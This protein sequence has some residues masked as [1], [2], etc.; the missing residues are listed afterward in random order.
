MKFFYHLDFSEREQKYVH[1]DMDILLEDYKKEELTLLMPVWSPGSYLVREYSRHLDS[2]NVSDSDF[3]KVNKNTWQIN[4]KDKEKI[5]LS[6]RLYCN[7]LTVRTNFIDDVHCLLVPPATFLIPEEKKSCN[8]FEV[9]VNLP[10]NWNQI[11]TGLEKVKDSENKF[12]GTDLHDFLD[13]PIEVG[14]YEVYKF[15]SFNKEHE[16]AIVGPKVY[17][18]EKM[19]TDVKKVVEATAKLFDNDVPYDKYSF[20]THLTTDSKGGIEHKNSTVLHFTKWDF[21]NPEQYKKGWL[22]LVSHEYFHLWN[23]K[24][25]KPDVLS[26][27]DYNNENYTRLLWFSEGFT[28]Y[29]DDLILRR[30]NIYTDEEYFEVIADILTKLITVSGRLYQTVEDASFD[31]WIKYYRKHEN[32]NNQHISYYVKGAVFGLCLDLEIR[33]QS[34]NKHS[35]EDVLK[36]MWSDV[37]ENND[38]AFTREEVLKYAQEFSNSDLTE[39]FKDFLEN[40]H[41]AD[42]NKYLNHVGLKHSIIDLGSPTLDINVKEVDGK[43]ICS[44]VKDKGTSYNYGLAVNDEIIAID[45]YRVNASSFAKRMKYFKVGQKIKLLLSRDERI[46]EKELVVGS[47]NTDYIRVEKLSNLS[48]EQLEISSK[49]LKGS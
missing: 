30:A 8:Y 6:Y 37:K 7:E 12:F 33:K 39:M 17:D 28:S 45:G 14:N 21:N 24:R 38:H 5:S 22:S 32:S 11:T 10:E 23:V 42:Y 43:L 2:F 49:W 27:F 13:C 36:R 4:V 44:F 34:Q 18:S 9:T 29:F 48:N 35:L 47:S 41:D 31:A 46:I 20:I 3:K 25:I 15:E 26:D 40:T 19:I 16:F 1:V